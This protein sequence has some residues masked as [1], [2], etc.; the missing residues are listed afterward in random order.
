[1]IDPLNIAAESS[2]NEGDDSK[3][4]KKGKKKKKR[5]GTL[6]KSKSQMFGGLRNYARIF[7]RSSSAEFLNYGKGHRSSISAGGHLEHPE[8]ELLPP[9]FAP[10]PTIP[11]RRHDEAEDPGL[12]PGRDEIELKQMKH[13]RADHGHSFYEPSRAGPS[14]LDGSTDGASASKPEEARR[15]A[16]STALVGNNTLQALYGTL[17]TP[18]LAYARHYESCV[19]LPPS[20]SHSTVSRSNLNFNM[21]HE[22][23]YSRM[24]NH[25]APRSPSGSALID[26]MLAS[27]P[28]SANVSPLPSPLASPVLAPIQMP[29]IGEVTNPMRGGHAQSKSASSVTSLRA[30][31]M[32]LLKT[33]KEAEERERKRAFE[34]LLNRTRNSLSEERRRRSTEVSVR[35]LESEHAKPLVERYDL[36][37]PLASGHQ[38]WPG[39]FR[40][41]SVEA[42]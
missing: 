3:S 16:S 15:V 36:P 42:N 9:V 28:T 34:D 24:T 21:L 14:R 2:E 25:S 13:R 35:N 30:S 23:S 20:T 18:A 26:K 12:A 31:S 5:A 38:T 32:D 10:M 40:R 6:P 1:M 11:D 4:K 8:L 39:S 41:S 27:Q 22:N 19:Y 33:L 37:A 7:T 17:V 29:S